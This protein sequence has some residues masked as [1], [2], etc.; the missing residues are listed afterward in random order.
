MKTLEAVKKVEPGAQAHA[1]TARM[2]TFASAA[3]QHTVPSCI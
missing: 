1:D 3:P 2:T